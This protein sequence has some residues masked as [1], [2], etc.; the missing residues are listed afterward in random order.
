MRSS[1]FSKGGQLVT[2]SSIFNCSA[3]EARGLC[4]PSRV[5]A[6]GF[7]FALSRSVSGTI[8]KVVCELRL[9][10]R[11]QQFPVGEQVTASPLT[12]RPARLM[13]AK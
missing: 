13:I 2:L 12:F 4:C 3:E 6:I 7:L 1:C 8:T 10:E 11:Q 5:N 9:T